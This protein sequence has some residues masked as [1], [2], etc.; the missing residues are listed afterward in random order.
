MK[1]KYKKSNSPMLANAIK[2][3]L[4]YANAHSGFCNCFGADCLGRLIIDFAYGADKYDV[5]NALCP[6]IHGKVVTYARGDI[7]HRKHRLGCDTIATYTT[8][9]LLVVVVALLSGVW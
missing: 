2:K 5:L 3:A 8:L 6:G 7:R 1:Q 4:S 9:L